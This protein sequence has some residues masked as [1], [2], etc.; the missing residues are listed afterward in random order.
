MRALSNRRVVLVVVVALCGGCFGRINVPTHFTPADSAPSYPPVPANQVQGYRGADWEHL[1]EGVMLVGRREAPTGVAVEDGFPTAND[2]HRVLGM[3]AVGTEDLP[4]RKEERQ[5]FL[6]S[7][8]GEI[9]GNAY[10]EMP[11]NSNTLHL[12]VLHLSSATPQLGFPDSPELLSE[13]L[14]DLSAYAP[15]GSEVERALDPFDP[16]VIEGKRGTC[17]A[18]RSAL[19]KD[20]LLNRRARRALSLITKHKGTI[21]EAKGGPARLNAPVAVRSLSTIVGCPLEDGPIQVAFNVGFDSAHPDAKTHL[22]AGSVM[23]QVYQRSVNDAELSSRAKDE[24]QRARAADDA[25]RNSFRK[26]E[27]MSCEGQLALCPAGT[28]PEQC[29]PFTQCMF[30]KGMNVKDCL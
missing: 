12:G 1:P 15:S 23:F 10:V 26:H 14:G 24:A 30:T 20:A 21:V 7:K 18:V 9:G 4:A 17:Y 16:F 27:C 28:A 8:V 19:R 11:A 5:A 29:E 22:G 3:L 2:P 6:A 25:N 13:P